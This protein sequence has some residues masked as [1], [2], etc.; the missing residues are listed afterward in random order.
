MPLHWSDLSIKVKAI[1]K[2][3]PHSASWGTDVG[4]RPD[5]FPFLVY[6]ERPTSLWELFE[7][8]RRW[9]S[10]CHLV[11]AGTRVSFEDV[12][13]RARL[14]STRIRA[15]GASPG[16]SVLVLAANS[17]D[18]VIATWATVGAGCVLVVGNPAWSAD[19][20][21]HAIK[22]SSPAV[23]LAD[24]S[25]DS[26][27]LRDPALIS[28][29]DA[30]T[31]PTG[32]GDASGGPVGYPHDEDDPAI[33]IFTSGTTGLP[34]GAVLSQRAC[35]AMQHTLLHQTG[36]LASVRNLD[37]PAEASLQTGPLFHIGGIQ[38]LLRSWLLGATLVFPTGRFDPHE[39]VEL[40]E[41]ERVVRWGAVPTMLRRVLE[42]CRVE[43]RDLSSVRS[44]T[45]GGS[46]VP[47]DLMD[48]VRKH[49]PGLRAGVSQIYGMTEAGGTLTMASASDG[50]DRP[51]TVGRPL[52]V[53]EL[54]IRDADHHGEG[55]ILARTPSQMTG[56]CDEDAD[57]PIDKD[58]WLHT[59]DLGRID[60]DGYLFV[61]GRLKDVIIRGGENI[62]AARVEAEVARLPG[63]RD[64]AVF[65]LPDDDLGEVV[66]AVVVPQERRQLEINVLRELISEHL[67]YFEVPTRWWLRY[68]NL[69]VN[70]AGKV[71][72]LVLRLEFPHE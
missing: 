38:G 4:R 71:D 50:V 48:A 31:A 40:L 16:D 20:L 37:A 2:V 34:K 9:G 72:K 55:E 64:V 5:G 1:M 42:V 70:S 47:V 7:S 54:R 8:G 58:G 56:Y 27:A 13:A 69:P 3:G 52:P 25:S 32:D 46:P 28:A 26:A 39:A 61:T 21:A 62:A 14:A 30:L 60:G 65:G 57:S 36:R 49:F 33:I 59:G 19:E 23:V 11:Q 29:L 43:A 17:I 22:V 44:I 24:D 68:D 15:L 45:L 66:A 18:L 67:A 35:I 12:A 41:S 51:G 10:R 63:V 6:S 53:V